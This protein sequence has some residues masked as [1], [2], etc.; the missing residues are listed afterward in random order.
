MENSYKERIVLGPE[1]R[2]MVRT[3][4]SAYSVIEVWRRL[5][6]AADFKVLRAERAALRR[7]DK[8]LEANRLFLK[9]AQE[10]EKR[11]G[12]AYSIVKL[13]DPPDIDAKPRPGDRLVVPEG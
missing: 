4:N 3:V 12:P 1:E 6:A 5:V 2:A 13:V 7:N 9:W 8:L 10:G 11:E